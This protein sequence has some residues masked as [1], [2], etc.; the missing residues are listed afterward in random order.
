MPAKARPKT[1]VVGLFGVGLDNR[2][3]HQRLTRAEDVILLGG[4]EETHA[5]MQDVAIHFNES[6]RKRGKKLRDAA[7]DEVTDL[8]QKAMDP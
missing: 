3:G 8:L 4:S 2:D 7:P 1:E 5:K 6:L